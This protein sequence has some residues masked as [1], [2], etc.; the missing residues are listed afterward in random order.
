MLPKENQNSED[1]IFLKST[2]ITENQENQKDLRHCFQ[3]HWKS[4][5]KDSIMEHNHALTKLLL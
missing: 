1:L 4:K 5:Q 3:N 2:S